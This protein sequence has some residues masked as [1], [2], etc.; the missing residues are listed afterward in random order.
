MSTNCGRCGRVLKDPR[1]IEAGFGK[2]CAAKMGITIPAKP[3]AKKAK[4]AVQ[5]GGDQREAVEEV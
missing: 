1:Y 5:E 4:P 3:K 2:V